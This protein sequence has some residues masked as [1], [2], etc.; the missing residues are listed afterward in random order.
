LVAAVDDHDRVL[1]LWR[2]RLAT[3]EWGR[4]LPGGIADAGE[5]P[6]DTAVRQAVEETGWKPT[7]VEPLVQFQPMPG[8]VDTPH[9][10]YVG[11]KPF[12]VG[13]PT[14]TEEAGRWLGVAR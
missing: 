11:Q 13:K 4:E 14:D 8:M 3:D 2:H 7:T 1:M 6:A 10:V 9:I 12:A 5:D